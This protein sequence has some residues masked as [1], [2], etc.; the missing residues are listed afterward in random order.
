MFPP[1]FNGIKSAVL[2]SFN[3]PTFLQKVNFGGLK[4]KFPEFSLTLKNFFFLTIFWPVVT[5]TVNWQPLNLASYSL[6]V[7]KDGGSFTT[8][9]KK[10][11][12]CK[13]DR[14]KRP[15]EEF[16]LRNAFLSV[17]LAFFKCS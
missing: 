17:F 6:D 10:E 15:Q 5:L 14:N 1:A 11:I 13:L 8:V 4:T 12:C 7:S 3:F 9:N 2:N 16:L